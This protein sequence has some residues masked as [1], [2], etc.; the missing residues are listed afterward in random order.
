MQVF[1]NAIRSLKDGIYEIDLGSTMAY[2]W[3]G[4]PNYASSGYKYWIGTT[5]DF[6]GGTTQ[7]ITEY[8]EISDS[9]TTTQVGT[10]IEKDDHN[11]SQILIRQS[12]NRLLAFY[13]EHNGLALRYRIS[14][15]PLDSSNWG[16]EITLNPV[17]AYS[18]ITPYQASNGNIFVFFRTAMGGGKYNWHYIKSTDGGVTFSSEILI[19]DDGNVQAYLISCQDGNKVHFTAS[20]GHP[21]SNSPLN[22]NI[23]H[24]YFDLI[25]ETIHNSIGVSQTIPA[26]TADMTLVV[27]TLSNDTSWILDVIVKNG[28]PRI[29]YAFY[30]SGINT[31]WYEKE[32]WYVE[33]DGVNWIN[34]TKI[35]STMSGYIEDDV[36]IQERCYDG[37]SR[38][39]SQNSDI[40]WMPKQVNGILEIHKVDISNIN[41]IIIEQ[42]TFNSLVDNWRPISVS[43]NKYNL[44]WLKKNNYN[45]YTD[46]N[47][48]LLAKTI[49]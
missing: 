40:I 12:D 22:I 3:F 19:F 32:L 10:V 38:F 34:N 43:S 11:Q 20:N 5:K 29:I 39:D 26:T 18:Y 45:F 21:Q 7:A 25:N 41:D 46:Y 35:S 8:D 4:R 36:S 16:N 27:E 6:G 37:A 47:I 48:N 44:L 49:S 9:F 31:L 30:P 13:T 24:L 23:Y 2:T 14:L 17:Q 28:N 33:F 1:W 42:I 15:N